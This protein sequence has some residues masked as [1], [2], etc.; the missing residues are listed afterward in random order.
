MSRGC[1][2]YLKPTEYVIRWQKMFQFGLAYHVMEPNCL[3]DHVIRQK[4]Y[5]LLSLTTKVRRKRDDISEFW[6]IVCNSEACKVLFGSTPKDWKM[7]WP[8]R[9]FMEINRFTGSKRVTSK[10]FL[11]VP[12][13]ELTWFEDRFSVRLMKRWSSRTRIIIFSAPSSTAN[14]PFS[15]QTRAK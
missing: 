3:L 14:F 13:V 5:C 15:F 12:K 8:F 10:R 6:S 1:V 2:H 9:H 4:K 11:T 7:V